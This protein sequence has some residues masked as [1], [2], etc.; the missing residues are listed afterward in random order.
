MKRRI[1]Y[2]FYI[3]VYACLALVF[4]SCAG[5]DGVD[6][7]SKQY[8]NARARQVDLPPGRARV[9]QASLSGEWR[10]AEGDFFRFEEFSDLRGNVITLANA[11]QSNTLDGGSPGSYDINTLLSSFEIVFYKDINIASRVVDAKL[12]F[13]QGSRQELANIEVILSEN[14]QILIIGGKKYVRRK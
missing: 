12:F 10:N 8:A 3:V 14:K 2:F 7:S 1:N 9:T 5:A 11:F 13:P 6:V 4:S